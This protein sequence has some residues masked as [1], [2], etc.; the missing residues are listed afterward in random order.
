MQASGEEGAVLHA[1]AGF[2]DD[3]SGTPAWGHL[4]LLAFSSWPCAI[5]YRIVALTR[6][7]AIAG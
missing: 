7:D 3:P 2:V 1:N 5:A 6:P 4:E